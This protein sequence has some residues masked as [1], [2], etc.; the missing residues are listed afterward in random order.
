MVDDI[1]IVVAFL[2]VGGMSSP[3]NTSDGKVD[4][5]S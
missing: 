4:V 3:K 1:T 5:W 2:N